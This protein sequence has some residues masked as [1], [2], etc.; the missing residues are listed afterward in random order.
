MTVIKI[1]FNDDPLRMLFQLRLDIVW[2]RIHRIHD[3][4]SPL[5]KLLRF[6][7]S[8]ACITGT[9]GVRPDSVLPFEPVPYAKS[10]RSDRTFAVIR[11]SSICRTET[12]V[13]VDDY[14]NE[15]DEDVAHAGMVSN[16]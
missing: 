11:R 9:N 15:K 13:N 4:Y 3:P 14:M 1:V 2:K 10:V 16:P 6:P 8:V 5:A 7:K 12:S